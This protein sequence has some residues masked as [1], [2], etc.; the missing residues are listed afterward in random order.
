MM[1]EMLV[2][3]CSSIH[4]CDEVQNVKMQAFLVD[5]CAKESEAEET[6][7]EKNTVS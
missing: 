5:E 7:G 6:L 4:M 2:T 3:H 1:H